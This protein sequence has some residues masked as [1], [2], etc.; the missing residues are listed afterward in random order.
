KVT[1]TT[2]GITALQ[3]D[4]KISGL[5]PELMRAALQQ[6]REARLHILGKMAEVLPAPRSELKPQV[7]RILSIKISPEK[8][9]AVIGPGGKN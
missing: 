3:M 6:A 2:E 4:I 1:G 8:I 7:P 9:G 5:S